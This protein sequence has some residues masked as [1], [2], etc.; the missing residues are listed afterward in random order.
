[1]IRMSLDKETVLPRDGRGDAAVPEGPASGGGGGVDRVGG[2]MMSPHPPCLGPT[3]FTGSLVLTEQPHPHGPKTRSTH[4]LKTKNG[5]QPLHNNPQVFPP[6][7]QQRMG[8][9]RYSLGGSF[10]HPGFGKRRRR[11][12]SDS[13]SDPVLPSNFLLGG[14]IFDPLNLNSL[15]DE[16]VSRTLNAETPKSS[17]L[18][19]RAR[20][21]V[22]ILVP[23]DI[24]D[25]LNLKSGGGEGEEG[26]GVL[27]SPMKNRK[28]HRNRHHGG[29]G[30]V[31]AQPEPPTQAEGSKVEAGGD[32]GTGGEVLALF[33]AS[34]SVTGELAAVPEAPREGLSG[35]TVPQSPLPYELNTTI[36][37]RDE[38]VP[39]ILPRRHTHPPLGS[40]SKPRP[41]GDGGHRQRKRRRTT[42]TRSDHSSVTPTPALTTA[43]P[44]T[45]HTPLVPGSGLRGQRSG[46]VVGGQQQPQSSFRLKP[47][48]KKN[49]FQHGNYS[50]YYGYH[51]YYGYRDG[52]VGRFEDPRLGLL[53]PDWFRGKTVL[54][55]GCSTGHLTLAIARHFNPA[56]ILGIDVDGRLVH[57]ARQN[58]RHFL[59]ER[60][61]Q[62][63]RGREEGIGERGGESKQT[64]EQSEGR[65]QSGT[66]M[67]SGTAEKKMEEEGQNEECSALEELKR[68]LT[69]LS[70]SSGSRGVGRP[71]PPFPLSFRVCRGP[72]A[73]PPLF[74]L[75][76]G[77][78]NTWNIP[79]QRLLHNGPTH[80]LSF[81]TSIRLDRPQPTTPHQTPTSIRLDRAQ[82]TNP[83]QT[84]TSIRLDRPQPTT[85]H[86]TPTSIRLDRAQSTNPHQTPTSIR[87]D[88]AQSTTPHHTPTSIRLD[89]AQSTN[90]HQTPTSIRLDR[91]QS[92]TPHQTPTSTRLDRPQPTTPHQTREDNPGPRTGSPPLHR[93]QQQEQRS[94]YMEVFSSVT[95]TSNRASLSLSSLEVV[96]LGGCSFSS[97]DY[98]EDRELCPHGDDVTAG[99][100]VILC[101]GVTK[102]VQ[103]HGGDGGVVRMFRQIY[104]HL[105]PGGILLL[106]PQPW[107]SYCR[108]KNIT[109]TTYRN[110]CDIRLRPDNFCC[111][112]TST[113][114][115]T[116]Y[117]LLTDTGFQRP[118][119]LFH[120]GPAPRK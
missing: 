87:L 52:Q 56:H 45:F 48:K 25:P 88:R 109:E 7:Q 112:L 72:M 115:F 47:Q 42:S 38:V 2:V 22:E 110:Y 20:D 43:P 73:A 63:A 15:M 60:L 54:D 81:A 66:K 113:V 94:V 106:E 95:H 114:G 6:G 16:E 98:M 44:N 41:H 27:V 93:A 37:C 96:W 101:L 68:T 61:T 108:S 26:G 13:Q 21:P 75:H 76:P 30:G 111:Y 50:R 9:R 4:P 86:Q 51:G 103:L 97:G 1:M 70:P 85:P 64:A 28:R 34:V 92:T 18:P 59:S 91:A 74:P 90:P 24:T 78:W 105:R 23:R 69:L 11:A 10:K 12:N 39:P 49:R 71:L 67:A 58:I 89:R 107:S 84:P 116:C 8:K 55:I 57:A 5:L 102:W 46:S 82:S 79:Q 120:K 29:G 104:T 3:G 40:T 77:P 19:A 62:D 53:R 35:S 65:T 17:P 119:Y 33:P 14:N 80:H 99:Y 100:D 31:G 32:S 117:R 118:I 36:N 83:H